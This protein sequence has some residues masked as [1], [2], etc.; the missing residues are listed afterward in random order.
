MTFDASESMAP[1][2]SDDDARN[3]FL[4]ATIAAL[5]PP[6]ETMVSRRAPAAA[7]AGTSM[8]DAKLPAPMTAIDAPPVA[9]VAG[10]CSMVRRRPAS[11]FGEYVRAIAR[12]APPPV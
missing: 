6:D 11:S 10:R 7:K 8:R 2:A 5:V 4:L 9:G 12:L 3:P 1:A